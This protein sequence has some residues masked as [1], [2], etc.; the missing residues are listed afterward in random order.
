[1]DPET[2]EK[3]IHSGVTLLKDRREHLR[4][5]LKRI[6]ENKA[7]GRSG[8]SV[9]RLMKVRQSY[10]VKVESGAIEASEEYVT[11]FSEAL[12]LPQPWADFLLFLAQQGRFALHKLLDTSPLQT[13]QS[14]LQQNLFQ[15][16]PTRIYIGA[17][18]SIPIT[19][20]HR[21]VAL[22]PMLIITRDYLRR[23]IAALDVPKESV[24]FL[25]YSPNP[26]C[27]DY[28]A[29]AEKDKQFFPRMSTDQ[30]IYEKTLVVI[31][32]WEWQILETKW[33]ED[34]TESFDRLRVLQKPFNS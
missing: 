30:F 7:G 32:V 27:L 34:F 8:A 26:M 6:R 3:Q 2:A 33:V 17:R 12:E 15:M 11:K 29:L 25:Q 24:P 31:D 5:L 18:A 20:L 4:Y 21:V 28:S 22:N 1:M 14:Y 9:A 10:L 19:E 16:M 13:Q 23:E